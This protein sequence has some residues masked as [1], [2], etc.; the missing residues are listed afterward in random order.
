RH[1]SA[2]TAR[3]SSPKR[4]SSA[5]LSRSPRSASGNSRSIHAPRSRTSVAAV[6]GSGVMAPASHV[7]P[8]AAHAREDGAMNTD[9]TALLSALVA[10]DSVN[11]SLV[12]GGAGEREAAGL[13]EA[14]A[15]D[16]GLEAER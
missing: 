11:P 7:G 10:V 9:L 2:L 6:P 15:R 3:V 1:R 16:A 14:W 5:R 13:V 8:S 12:A 4:P